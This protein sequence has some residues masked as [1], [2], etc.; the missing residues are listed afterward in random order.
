M[1]RDFW[2]KCD[3]CGKFISYDD[4]DKVATRRLLT[5]DSYFSREIY[6]TL[7]REHSDYLRDFRELK[8]E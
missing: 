4:F 1:N 8:E 3:V 7:C 2:N 6:E 5:P